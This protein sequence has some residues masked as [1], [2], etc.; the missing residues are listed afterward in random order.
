[1]GLEIASQSTS[2]SLSLKRVWTRVVFIF[3]FCCCSCAVNGLTFQI[4]YA[5][6]FAV[7]LIVL[8]YV[9]AVV[10]F[11]RFATKLRFRRSKCCC[12]LHLFVASG[13]FYWHFFSLFRWTPKLDLLYMWMHASSPVIKLSSSI[14]CLNF[15]IL[16]SSWAPNRALFPSLSCSFTLI[17][18]EITWKCQAQICMRSF[19]NTVCSS[20]LHV[21]GCVCVFS[22]NIQMQKMM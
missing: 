13:C 9:D 20:T 7:S 2:Y 18:S 8:F 6:D 12:S 22:L 5:N 3:D 19:T 1:M 15:L 10:A 17:F 14:P 16:T 11:V 21:W 4:P